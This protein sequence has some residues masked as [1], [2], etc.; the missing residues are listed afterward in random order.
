MLR[1]FVNDVI[2]IL[3]TANWDDIKEAIN[4]VFYL[5]LLWCL[6]FV[7]SCDIFFLWFGGLSSVKTS[8]C[9][10]SQGLRFPVSPSFSCA[11][12]RVQGDLFV[13]ECVTGVGWRKEVRT[14]ENGGVYNWLQCCQT[15]Q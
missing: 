14:K 8:H 5:L 4:V 13:C 3:L 7:L 2:V 9:Y 6:D 1:L 11:D 12:C 15:T 10:G